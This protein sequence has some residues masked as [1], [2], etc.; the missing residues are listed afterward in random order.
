MAH[1]EWWHK[2]L[3]NSEVHVIPDE[4]HVTLLVRQA[5]AILK[6]AREASTG[7]M[8]LSVGVPLQS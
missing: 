7:S 3:P 1:A 8:R 5:D 6:A 2:K 4:G